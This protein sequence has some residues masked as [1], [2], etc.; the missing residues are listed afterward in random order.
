MSTPSPS[1]AAAAALAP[2]VDT[3]DQ[4]ALRA[5]LRDLLSR[6][7]DS[8]AVRRAIETETGT[9]PALWEA[10]AGQVGVAALGLPESVSGAGGSYLETHLAAEELGRSLAPSP[11]LGSA[12]LAAYAVLATG[13]A[14][15]CAE[16][17]PR[18]AEGEI[19]ALCW[20][21]ETG[22]HAPGV[23]A[24]RS[25]GADDAT[26][27]LDGT[28]HYV[29][30][31][32]TATTLVVLARD[33]DGALSFHVCPADAG[34]VMATREPVMDPTRT[35]ATVRFDGVAARVLA[36]RSESICLVHA[37]AW[38]AAS[39]EAVG[40]AQASLDATVAYT[41][42]RT[43]FGRPI[44]GF[45]AL[46]HRMADMYVRTETARS[47]SYAAAA[48]VARAF[49]LAADESATGDERLAAAHAAEVEAAAAKVSAT[50]AASWI[51]GESIQLHG[52]VGIT[53]E[54]D[55]HLRFK[56]A[57]GLATMFGQPH[58]LAEALESAAGLA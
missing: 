3:E 4:A 21:G 9:D 18:I 51:T 55:V 14:A 34:G 5:A 6:R 52:G 49:E 11:F 26:S 17:L 36:H 27:T 1:P 50:R 48:A 40:V 41:A 20:A 15:A 12:V 53:W 38:A 46:K 16:H 28:A 24:G 10:L 35:L 39:A 45:Q 47:L 29:L 7:S 56:R 8:P 44:G 54:Y 43:Q 33:A 31:G 30:G 37:A 42:E 58:E 25:G 32:D 2:G 22:W 23:T 57:H 13:D 19:Y